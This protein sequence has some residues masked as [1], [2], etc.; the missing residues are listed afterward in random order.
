MQVKEIANLW[1]ININLG[2][3]CNMNCR[4]CF[5]KGVLEKDVLCNSDN[6]SSKLL[7]LVRGIPE[8]RTSPDKFRIRFTGG[9]PLLYFQKMKNFV[10]SLKDIKD[11]FQFEVVFNGTLITDE[12]VDFLNEYEFKVGIS[13]D[14]WNTKV[15]RGINVVENDELMEKICRIKR[16]GFACVLTAFNS[17]FNKIISYFKEKVS[18]YREDI[19][20]N[21]NPVYDTGYLADEELVKFN[22]EEFE[23]TTKEFFE[24]ITLD[25]FYNQNSPEHYI[26][27][28][29]ISRYRTIFSY[30]EQGVDIT[31]YISCGADYNHINV[32]TEGNLL[33]C[34]NTSKLLGNIADT[35]IENVFGHFDLYKNEATSEC[36]NCEA[37][38]ICNGSC[39]F[40][41]YE[42]RISYYCRLQKIIISNV[43]NC[44]A[45]LKAEGEK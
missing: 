12:I 34:H 26:L 7:E 40:V 42:S 23:S 24:G 33:V 25:Q 37:K 5:Q 45:R 9:E 18:K 1:L 38:V 14:G 32:D 22:W 10:H 17:D 44:L 2:D 30:L 6:I 35:S 13:N 8:H 43:N 19:R 41:P 21:I 16:V 29:Y 15:T 20:V 27:H 36:V 11:Y 4:Y 39:P 28:K 3:K 31:D